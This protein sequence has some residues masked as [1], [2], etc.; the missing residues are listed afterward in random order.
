[1]TEQSA[2]SEAVVALGKKLVTELG[3]GDSVD[4]LGRWMAHYVA[5]LV[6]KAEAAMDEDRSA[7]QA[8]LRDAIL[9]LWA[10]RYE[11]PTGKRPFG[12]FEPILRTLASLDP[13][14]LSSRYFSL[15]RSPGDESDESEETRQ[16]LGVARNLDHVSKV[17]IDYCLTLA[18]S[19]ALDQSRE[20]VELAKAAGIDD[21][22][23]FTMIQRYT[24]HRDLMGKEDPNVYQRRALEDRREKLDAF[25][26][27][28]SILSNE[29]NNRLNSLPPVNEGSDEVTAPHRRG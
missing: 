26:S 23:E 14:S 13:E 5:E 22:F 2:H 19:P 17:L 3:L 15:S 29:I 8:H 6:Q 28:A 11:L 16:W 25:L 7:E 1:M 24:D 12:E 20:W 4:T 27:A 21:S 10:H 9:V 18:A